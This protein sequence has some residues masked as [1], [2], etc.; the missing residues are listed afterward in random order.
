MVV[1]LVRSEDHYEGVYEALRRLGD[2]LVKKMKEAK[3]IMVK[4]NFV[5]AYTS[6]SA[7]PV[8]SVRAVLDFIYTHVGERRVLIA[9]GPTIGS[10]REALDNYGY[11]ELK[12]AYDVAFVDLNADAGRAF[13]VYDSS[14]RKRVSI[15][16]AE[17]ALKSDFRISICRPKT[18]DTVIVTLAI[19]NLVMGAIKSPYKGRMHQG[20]SAINL[21][22]ALMA[23]HLMPELAV[24]DGYVGMEGNGPVDGSAVDWGIAMAGLNALEVDGVASWMMGFDPYEIGYLYLL[25]VAGYGELK[26]DKVEVLG[27]SPKVWR[28]RFRPHRGYEAQKGWISS[29]DKL[30]EIIRS[31]LGKSSYLIELKKP[32]WYF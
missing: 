27:E 12:R 8:D 30:E 15:Y 24:I 16:V 32:R 25:H 14:L 21:N 22:I 28:R 17:H 26:V 31:E 20:H 9:E 6:L 10:F 1:S 4:P 3:D 23:A 13:K 7:T 18:H 29:K 11:L 5:S 19:K 2:A